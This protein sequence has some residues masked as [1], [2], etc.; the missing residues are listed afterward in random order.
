M[1]PSQFNYVWFIIISQFKHAATQDLDAEGSP[2][3]GR[4]SQAILNGNMWPGKDMNFHGLPSGYLTVRH[5]S[6]DP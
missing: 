1:N 3:F 2:T 6:H 4:T 5:G